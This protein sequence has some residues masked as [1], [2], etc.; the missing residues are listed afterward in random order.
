MPVIYIPPPVIE[1]WSSDENSGRKFSVVINISLLDQTKITENQTKH[2]NLV[3]GTLKEWLLIQGKTSVSIQLNLVSDAI[4]T[5]S[6]TIYLK[7]SKI[8]GQ[9]TVTYKSL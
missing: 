3:Q 8:I 5:E 2:G 4:S 1:F 6:I 7:Q 9:Y